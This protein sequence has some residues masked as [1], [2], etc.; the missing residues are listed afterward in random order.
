MFLTM[1]KNDL[2]GFG[3]SDCPCPPAKPWDMNLDKPGPATEELLKI[4]N[5]NKNQSFCD[6]TDN[7]IIIEV[8][9]PG[10]KKEDFNISLDGELLTIFYEVK[11]ENK[12]SK[13]LTSR[14]ESWKIPQGS[15]SENISASYDAGVLIVTIKKEE[16]KKIPV[17]TIKVE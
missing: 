5:T 13:F 4:L 11:K 7:Q 12:A 10:L 6:E 8:V 3:Y 14:K 16:L 1:S 17:T 2:L 9:A 15:I